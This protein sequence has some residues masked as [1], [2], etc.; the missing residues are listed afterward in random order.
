MKGNLIKR[1]CGRATQSLLPLFVAAVSLSVSGE[2]AGEVYFGFAP[3]D[4]DP[5]TIVAQGSGKNGYS[6]AAI[7]LDP[8]ANPVVAALKGK[9]IT[10][11]R[12]YMRADYRQAKKRTSSIN[13]RQG[14]LAAEPVKNYADFYEGWNEIKLDEPVEITDEPIFIGPMVYETSGCPYPFVAAP[15]GAMPGGYSISLNKEA[16]QTL[17]QRGNLLMHVIIDAQPEDMPLA[18][19]ASPCNVPSVVAPNSTFICDLTLHNYSATPIKAAEITTVA[20]N[21]DTG[22]FS[23]FIIDPPIAPFDSRTFEVTLP[24]GSVEDPSVGYALVVTVLNSTATDVKPLTPFDLHVTSNA[25]LRIPLVEEFT[26]MSCVNCPFMAYYLDIALEEFNKPYVYISRHTGFVN[27]FFTL[28][29]DKELLYLFGDGGTYNPAIMYDRTVRSESDAW[30][31]YKADPNPN[32][33]AYINAL[34]EASDRPGY[35]KIL[36]D[37]EISDGEVNCVVRGRIADG[38]DTD[39]LFLCAYL[40]EN[41]I[42]AEAPYTQSG[43]YDA[44]EDAPEDL[45][46]R[47]RHNGIVRVEFNKEAMGCPLE[48]DPVTKEFRVDFG[49]SPVKP[50]WKS[51]NCETVA[52]I[53]RVNK[54]NLRDNYVLNAGGTRWNKLVDNEAGVGSAVADSNKVKIYVAQDRRIAV[55]G[56]FLSL[57]IWSADGRHMAATSALS[58]GVYAVSV[59]LPDGSRQVSKIAVR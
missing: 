28:P 19:Q 47:F 18:A 27:D 56:D 7:T 3:L 12:C 14:S 8:Q 42:P 54:D 13:I 16:W 1:L 55:E 17:S 39:G 6:E 15:G 23:Q 35:A 21:G 11:V 32:P 57:D 46:D 2:A 25:F 41:G 10:G 51:E 34:N 38:I 36:V 48:V 44:P 22:F 20:D 30:P 43:L 33:L 59:I 58:A 29:S 45:I 52:F 24:T 5:E 26:S 37:S 31:V 40:I 49:S 9:K 50:G 53:C 4:P